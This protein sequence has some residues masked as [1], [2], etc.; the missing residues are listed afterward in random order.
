MCCLRSQS[1][2]R[3]R[4]NARRQTL[5]SDTKLK[6]I[7]WFAT[8]INTDSIRLRND[9]QLTQRSIGFS[10]KCSI[11][12]WICFEERS[13]KKHFAIWLW[14]FN[15]IGHLVFLQ[16]LII[17]IHRAC[18]RHRHRHIITYSII[19][20]SQRVFLATFCPFAIDHKSRRIWIGWLD[21]IFASAILRAFAIC[22]VF[23]RINK[24]C[25]KNFVLLSP[26][27]LIYGR[28]Y[29]SR[30]AGAWAWPIVPTTF[31]SALENVVCFYC[32]RRFEPYPSPCLEPLPIVD[33]NDFRTRKALFDALA[34]DSMRIATTSV[35]RIEEEAQSREEEGKNTRI[36]QQNI[37]ASLEFRCF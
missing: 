26:S 5:A 32:G 36:G 30:Y 31:H 20:I 27:T 4:Y 6:W 15:P 2:V 24:N 25:V 18:T 33:A 37:F 12:R 21:K 1:M 14:M 35:N 9:K 17:I 34:V 22:F 16:F 29:E 8:I 3:L 23:V 11:M 13:N 19:I 7:V 28:D 10:T